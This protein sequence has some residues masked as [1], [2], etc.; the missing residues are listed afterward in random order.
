MRSAFLPEVDLK[1]GHGSGSGLGQQI[2]PTV[3][4]TE[5]LPLLVAVVGFCSPGMCSQALGNFSQRP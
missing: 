3:S 2:L 5:G 1:R 4:L